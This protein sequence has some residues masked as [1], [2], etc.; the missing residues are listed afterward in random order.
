[1]WEDGAGRWLGSAGEVCVRVRMCKPLQVAPFASL[2]FGIK[3]LVAV[4][5]FLPVMITQWKKD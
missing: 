3:S 5:R 1:V 2:L 4:V